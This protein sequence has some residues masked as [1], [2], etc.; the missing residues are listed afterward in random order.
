M[1]ARSRDP[2]SQ[3][4]FSRDALKVAIGGEHRQIVANA[5]LGKQCVDRPDLNAAAA[6]QVSKIC[7]L[8]MIVP[9]RNDH[10]YRGKPIDNLLASLRPRKSLKQLLQDQARR[11]DLLSSFDDAG[12]LLY[13]TSTDGRVAAKRKRPDTGIDEYAQLRDRSAL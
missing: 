4:A 6:T 7:G 3:C 1:A 9:V 12:K 2:K 8:D 5:Q 10:R 11:E 13:L